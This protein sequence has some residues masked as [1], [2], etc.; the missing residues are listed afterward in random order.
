MRYSTPGRIVRRRAMNVRWA[1]I[2]GAVCVAELLVAARRRAIEEKSAEKQKRRFRPLRP[3]HL[4]LGI[5]LDRVR[6]LPLL[7]RA[8]S[9]QGAYNRDACTR[10]WY[11]SGWQRR[12]ICHWRKGGPGKNAEMERPY[13]LI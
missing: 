7:R 3:G 12:R 6:R 11:Q 4:R 2:H 10:R 1:T 8:V 13:D 5:P 9:W